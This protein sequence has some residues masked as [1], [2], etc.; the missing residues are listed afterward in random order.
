MLGVVAIRVCGHAVV[1]LCMQEL[2]FYLSSNV[3]PAQ[4]R[5][6]ACMSATLIC[7]I[8]TPEHREGQRTHHS[9]ENRSHRDPRPDEAEATRA[10]RPMRTESKLQTPTSPTDTASHGII[11]GPDSEQSNQDDVD[12]LYEKQ[13]PIPHLLP[14][15]IR[16]G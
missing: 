11:R 6:G 13:R 2:V 8:Q 12:L 1:S 3:V 5:R 15:G 9:V 14:G 16:A 4:L 7:R 10:L